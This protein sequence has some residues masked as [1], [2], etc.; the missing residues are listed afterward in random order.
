[1][2]WSG[3]ID[4]LGTAERTRFFTLG[5]RLPAASLPSPSDEAREDDEMVP[6]AVGPPP[7]EA[8]EVGAGVPGPASR[9]EPPLGGGG[10]GVPD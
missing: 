10:G 2:T 8:H 7:L 1:M 3:P 5:G 4:A 9:A 6:V